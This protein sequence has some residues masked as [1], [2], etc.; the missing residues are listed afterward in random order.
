MDYVHKLGQFLNR[1][2]WRYWFH[3]WIDFVS[4]LQITLNERLPVPVFVWC[5]LRHQP[6]TKPSFAVKV[7]Q[8]TAGQCCKQICPIPQV[9]LCCYDIR[10]CSV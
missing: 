5:G 8:M 3:C 4:L 1:V 2:I 6:V 9:C 7:V 10:V